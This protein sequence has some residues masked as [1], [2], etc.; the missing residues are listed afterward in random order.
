M[1]EMLKNN[2]FKQGSICMIESVYGLSMWAS[3]FF[4]AAINSYG[5]YAISGFGISKWC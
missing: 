5:S 2:P 3:I 4:V 1:V